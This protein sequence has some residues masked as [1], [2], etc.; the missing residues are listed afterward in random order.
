MWCEIYHVFKICPYNYNLQI[1]VQGASS[2]LEEMFFPR[3]K[4]HQAQT[5]DKAP[6]TVCGVS[7][8]LAGGSHTQLPHKT[9][10]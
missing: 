2:D 4:L 5:K 8:W 3:Q 6:T 7:V 10:D 9:H 1:E